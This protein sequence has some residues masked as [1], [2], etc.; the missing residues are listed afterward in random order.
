MNHY[1]HQTLL[2]IVPV[3]TI[4]GLFLPVR[5][6]ES[7]RLK[8][9]F[10]LAG[11]GVCIWAFVFL[12][13]KQA[14]S[15]NARAI[16][17]TWSE[18]VKHEN[19]SLLFGMAAMAL[20]SVILGLIATLV[21]LWTFPSFRAFFVSMG[22]LGILLCIVCFPIAFF[23][24]LAGLALF[25]WLSFALCLLI[26]ILTLLRLLIGLRMSC[27]T[28]PGKDGRNG[29]DGENGKNGRDGKDG[30]IGRSGRD[31]KSGKD[32]EN[33]ENG[34]RSGYKSDDAS[35]GLLLSLV[36]SGNLG[37]ETIVPKQAPFKVSRFLYMKLSSDGEKSD[38]LQFDL[39]TTHGGNGAVWVLVPLPGCINKVLVDGMPVSG[40]YL[41]LSGQTI[42]LVNAESEPKEYGNQSFAPLTVSFQ[43]GER[44]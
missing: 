28:T 30:T 10:F 32:G 19:V 12:S 29:R 17:E 7:G 42:S 13:T 26:F 11:V 4:I 5:I 21:T 14:V 9:R 23:L 3:V 15:G 31:G 16:A 41:L 40:A 34:K 35:S 27:G 38:L 6:E 18:G 36:L 8:W 43:I 33:G 25:L 1:L 37:K 39:V 22:F 20:V 44:E 24:F 2:M